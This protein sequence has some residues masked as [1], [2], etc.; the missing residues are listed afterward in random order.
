[1]NSLYGRFGLNI[2][3]KTFK[4]IVN[5]EEFNFL[6]D[7]DLLDIMNFT[8]MKE[9]FMI[10]YNSKEKF[11]NKPNASVAI[12]SAI[13]AYARIEMSKYMNNSD[14]II[15]Y[16]DTDCIVVDRPIADW[17]VGKEIGQ[18]K[19]ENIIKVGYFVG[20]KIYFEELN[21]NQFISKCKGIGDLLTKDDFIKLY[22]GETI[23]KEKILF[24]KDYKN[25]AIK[26][27]PR[28]IEVSSDIKRIKIFNNKGHWIDTKPVSV[29]LNSF[30]EENN[31][32]ATTDPNIGHIRQES[33]SLIVYSKGNLSLI[34]SKQEHF[35]LIPQ[36]PPA[37][38]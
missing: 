18:M 26:I 5:I 16:I 24:I 31:L 6:A 23:I 2:A 15:Y 37:P 22:L 17:L 27:L 33:G 35:A 28:D 36:P 30:K 9:N 21:N 3:N 25:Q 32:L 13:T 38:G 4:K 11:I 1:M 20:P 12:A 29:I 10:D 19:L 34:L 7:E 8:G 14:F